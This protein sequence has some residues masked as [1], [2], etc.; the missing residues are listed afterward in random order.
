MIE[1]KPATSNRLV[2]KSGLFGCW[3]YPKF[4]RFIDD[5]WR[6]LPPYTNWHLISLYQTLVRIERDF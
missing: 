4:V 3:V 1:H 5:H 6:S 2:N